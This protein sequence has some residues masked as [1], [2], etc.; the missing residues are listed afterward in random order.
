MCGVQ[1]LICRGLSGPQ[2]GCLCDQPHTPWR[3]PLRWRMFNLNCDR[4]FFVWNC[5][6]LF[7][8][9]GVQDGDFATCLWAFKAGSTEQ[10]ATWYREVDRYGC[11]FGIHGRTKYLWRFHAEHDLHRTTTG[12]HEV[13]EDHLRLVPTPTSSALDPLNWSSTRKCAIL[14]TMAYLGRST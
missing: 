14:T 11:G 8:D 6:S 9:T 3:S 1:I 2:H 12:S 7:H 4:P 5:T 13:K 10:R